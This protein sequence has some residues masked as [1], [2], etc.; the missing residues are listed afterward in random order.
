MHGAAAGICAVCRAG[1]PG[2]C[3]GQTAD[4]SGKVWR[5]TAVNAVAGAGLTRHVFKRGFDRALQGVVDVNV[6]RPGFQVFC[7]R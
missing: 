6:F 5:R 4:G 7:D 1:K 2:H 3:A